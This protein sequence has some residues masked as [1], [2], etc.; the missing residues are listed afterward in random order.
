MSTMH[1]VRNSA[2]AG[3]L[4]GIIQAGVYNPWDR[5]LYLSVKNNVS[6]L[7]FNNWT[8]PWHGFAQAVVQRTIS[9]GL[10]FVLQDQAKLFLEPRFNFSQTTN[11]FFVGV[12]AGILNGVILNQIATIK[13]HSWAKEGTTFWQA[14]RHMHRDGG[15]SPFF[16]G[17]AVTGGRD[18]I[19]GVVYETSRSFLFQKLVQ[20]NSKDNRRSRSDIYFVSNMIAASFATASSGPLNYVRVIIYSTPPSEKPPGMIKALA[21]LGHSTK[22]QPGFKN[23]ISFLQQRLR[24]GWGTARVGVGMAT[25]Q[26]LYEYMKSKLQQYDP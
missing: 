20:W 18:M 6:F 3:L 25:G 9:G 14:A 11:Q 16:K 19:F 4:S 10:Y 26:H 17:V 15:F 2:I 13:Y 23:K 1:E 22:M 24:I 5:A 8:H 12:T 7:N 21:D